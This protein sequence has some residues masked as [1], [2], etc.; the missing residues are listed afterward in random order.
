MD[1][2]D[3]DLQDCYSSLPAITE[4]KIKR[5]STDNFGNYGTVSIFT[6]HCSG[7]YIFFNRPCVSVC[8]PLL[9]KG[10]DTFPY[11]EHIVGVTILNCLKIW[12]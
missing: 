8:F 1:F 7:T 2:R 5:L 4:K 6:I 9:P 11:N 10:K 3:G 12:Y